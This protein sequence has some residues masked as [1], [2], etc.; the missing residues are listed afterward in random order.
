MCFRVFLSISSAAS[1]LPVDIL[2][3]LA[4]S[5]PCT[6][7]TIE[8]NSDNVKSC[9]DA[10]SS[11]LPEMRWTETQTCAAALQMSNPPS[12]PD[13]PS[14]PLMQRSKWCKLWKFAKRFKHTNAFFVVPP[15][16]RFNPALTDNLLLLWCK[17]W[18]LDHIKIWIN[19]ES[20]AI[21]EDLCDVTVMA[22]VICLIWT[23]CQWVD[24]AS[25]RTLGTLS[26]YW[27][28]NAIATIVLI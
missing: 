9:K 12:A 19:T 10:W 1:P 5:F 28:S 7:C 4:F 25:R 18:S 23:W 13:L 17:F 26:P 22:S 27:W 3:C 16:L 11:F 6:C 24:G 14:T 21:N 8:I 20:G 2:T 15:P